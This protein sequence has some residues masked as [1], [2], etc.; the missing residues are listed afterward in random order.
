MPMVFF[1]ISRCIVIRANSLRSCRISRLI[2][3]AVCGIGASTGLAPR[4]YWLFQSRRF[5][6]LTPNSFATSSALLP[7]VSQW[8]TTERL[9][10]CRYRLR[11]GDPLESFSWV[12]IGSLR[13]KY[14]CP[15]FRGKGFV[16]AAQDPTFCHEKQF[17]G[18]TVGCWIKDQTKKNAYLVAKGWIEDHGWVPL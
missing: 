9:N 12:I 17:G 2:S 5:H 11:F 14:L 18:A 15:I 4:P 8:S 3:S 7:L 13:P 1:K 16:E 10:S 6:A